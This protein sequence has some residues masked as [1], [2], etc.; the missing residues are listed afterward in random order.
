MDQIEQME[1]VPNRDYLLSFI[2]RNNNGIYINDI[3]TNYYIYNNLVNNYNYYMYNQDFQAVAA[4]AAAGQ[5]VVT[6]SALETFEKLRIDVCKVSQAQ[7]KSAERSCEDGW[8]CSV[9]QSEPKEEE[10]QEEEQEEQEENE[11]VKTKCN[12][13]FHSKCLAKWVVIKT[14]CPMCRASLTMKIT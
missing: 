13:V 14:S 10:E 8:S 7:D 9:C 11:M 6:A 5:N 3:N 1:P 2:A 4:G 12:H